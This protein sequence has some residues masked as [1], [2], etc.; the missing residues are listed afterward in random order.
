MVRFEGIDEL[1]AKDLK[2]VLTLNREGAYDDYEMAQ[3]AKEI[4]RLYQSKG[5]LQ[6][7][8]RFTRKVGILGDEVTFHI[9]EGPY[10]RVD[11]IRFV[12]NRRSPRRRC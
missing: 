5:Y 12:G 1:S 7:K 10:F 4:H 2:A 11:E 9:K 8:V 6:A 3:S